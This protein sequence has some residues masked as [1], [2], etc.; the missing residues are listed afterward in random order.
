MFQSVEMKRRETSPTRSLEKRRSLPGGAAVNMYQR[1]ASA[2]CSSSTDHGSM[3]LS[4]DFDI[5]CPS[6]SRISP[7]EITLRKAIH[8]GASSVRCS[9]VA[10]ACS[11]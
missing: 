10:S 6:A 5:F 8:S 7:T 11:V 9:S 1:T 3:T 4:P 2:P